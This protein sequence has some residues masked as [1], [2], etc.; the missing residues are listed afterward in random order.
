MLDVNKRDH[1]R[2]KSSIAQ[3][4]YQAIGDSKGLR[5]RTR[6]RGNDLHILCESDF[7]C[8]SSAT[9]VTRILQAI[10]A[11]DGQVPSDPGR[12]IY[13]I[14]LYGRIAGR[15]RP[16][17]IEPIELVQTPSDRALDELRPMEAP[18]TPANDVTA[19]A[20]GGSTPPATGS[21]LLISN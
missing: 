8:P 20:G 7:Q 9:V 12:P 18:S 2:H 4:V 14:I 10:E 3:W 11:T 5:L 6:L 16:E 15:Q 17:W 19:P 21:A 13:Q 1:T